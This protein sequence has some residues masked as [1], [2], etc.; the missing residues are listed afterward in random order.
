MKLQIT[1]G[2]FKHAEYVTGCGW[3]GAELYTCSDDK[4]V[5]K[6]SPE[7]DDLGLVTQLESC[8]TSLH[9]FP[10]GV[11]LSIHAALNLRFLCAPET[12]AIFSLFLGAAVCLE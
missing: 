4:T 12:A 1:N 11:F 2:S 3:V 10:S 9:W 5:R 7:G 6:L 8:P